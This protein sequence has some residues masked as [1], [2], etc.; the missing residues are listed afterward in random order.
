MKM[1]MVVTAYVEVADDTILDDIQRF[2]RIVDRVMQGLGSIE[3]L[4]DVDFSGA[5]VDEEGED[6]FRMS[7]CLHKW[8]WWWKQEPMDGGGFRYLIGRADED[9]PQI[10]IDRRPPTRSAQESNRH[11]TGQAD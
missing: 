2:D 8:P 6:P 11:P 9:D 10:R 1:R 5:L 3:E 7:V 4:K